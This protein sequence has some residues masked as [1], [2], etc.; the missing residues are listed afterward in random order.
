MSFPHSFRYTPGAYLVHPAIMHISLHFLQVTHYC[1][2]N[3]VAMSAQS[4]PVPTTEIL[5]IT[6]GYILGHTRNLVR[7]DNLCVTSYQS[8][9]LKEFFYGISRTKTRRNE[10]SVRAYHP[11]GIPNSSWSISLQTTMQLIHD[12]LFCPNSIILVDVG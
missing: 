8:F 10:L 1:I 5:R 12:F 2:S 4:T 6:L 11:L 3:K 7:S 9:E